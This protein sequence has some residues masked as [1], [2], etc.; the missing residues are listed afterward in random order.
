MA[1]QHLIKRGLRW[2]V[3]DGRSIRIWQDQW[4]NTRST[5]KVITPER[6]GNQI[7]IVR[8]LLREDGLEWDIGL[9]RDLFLPQD[10]EA[11]LNI[12]ISESFTKDRMVWAEEKKGHFLVRS[13]Y[14]LAR[15]SGA[16]GGDTSCSDPTKMQGVWRGVWSMNLP[17]KIKH[18]A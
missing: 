6:P 9:V 7:K 18:F 11:I 12:P 16:E 4:L 1:A 5:Y 14:W 2:Q 13:A 10:A 3:G 8:D 17:N 15:N